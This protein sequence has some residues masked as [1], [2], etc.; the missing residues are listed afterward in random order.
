M[1]KYNMSR[2]F[3]SL[4]VIRDSFC[5]Q[6]TTVSRRLGIC[7]VKFYPEG[8]NQKIKLTTQKAV[9]CR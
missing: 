1:L 4:V 3:F 5:G 7:D 6:I 2:D 9:I 8:N